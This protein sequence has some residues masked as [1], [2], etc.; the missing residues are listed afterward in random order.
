MNRVHKS[1]LTIVILLLILQGGLLFLLV[2]NEGQVPTG[3]HRSLFLSMDFYEEAYESVGDGFVYESQGVKAVIVPHH[4]FVK[5]KIASLFKSLEENNYK[6]II[7]IG[8]DHMNDSGFNVIVS[9]Y[10]WQTPYGQIMSDRKMF[11]SLLQ[12]GLVNQNEFAM[13]AEFSISG[14]VSFVKKS[15]PTAVFTPIVIATGTS[16]DNLDRLVK[17]IHDN[18]TRN[19]L[20]IASVDFSHYRTAT[21]AEV[22]DEHSIEVVNS[23]NIS[24]ALS[25]DVD[26][27]ESIYMVM[28][29]ASAA[30]SENVKHLSHTNSGILLPAQKEDA[31]TH[32]IFA[33]Y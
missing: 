30:G 32:N 20:I 5:G 27:P 6:Q 17:V 13:G 4:L 16:K 7:M 31:V 8:P 1:T 21:E 19:S 29:L 14:L 3:T 26:S 33:F 11:S 9:D 10:A 12:S 24:D 22:V 28:N 15:F 23:F 2:S 18:Q 25:L